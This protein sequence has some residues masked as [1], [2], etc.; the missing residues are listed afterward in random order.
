MQTGTFQPLRTTEPPESPVACV[1]FATG[2][3][4]GKHGI[5]D[6]LKVDRKKY[7]P[8]IGL[9]EIEKPKFLFH[10]LPIKGPK[11]TNNRKGTPFYKYLADRGI[12]TSAIR[13][14]LSLP[15]EEMPNGGLLCGLGVSDVRKTWGTFFT[16]LPT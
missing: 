14:P 4:P 1:S 8:D 15:P 6:F 7:I 16:S 13:M 9:V 3:N 5:F 12:T 2:T 10:T 11:I